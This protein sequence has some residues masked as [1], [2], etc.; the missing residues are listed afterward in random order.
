MV[1]NHADKV[2]DIHKKLIIELPPRNILIPT[3]R[4]AIEIKWKD[5]YELIVAGMVFDNIEKVNFKNM[6]KELIRKVTNNQIEQHKEIDYRKYRTRI[7]L[8]NTDWDEVKAAMV[9]KTRLRLLQAHTVLTLESP[10]VKLAA[11]LP[12]E[13][14]AYNERDPAAELVLSL[15]EVLALF[16][17]S[18][19]EEKMIEKDAT[20]LADMV[21]YSKKRDDWDVLLSKSTQ[22]LSSGKIFI[23][24]IQFRASR[25]GFDPTKARKDAKAVQACL[26][27]QRFIRKYQ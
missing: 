12:D 4:E 5:T 22:L 19:P 3:L 7:G 13:E 8:E 14:G 16:M 21:K 11:I 1:Q 25:F 27:M 20:E 24:E 9:D 2:N 26:V 18:M 6:D 10:F 17:S 23:D 15:R